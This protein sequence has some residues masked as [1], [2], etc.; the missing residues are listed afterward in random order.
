MIAPADSIGARP[1]R[2]VRGIA[3]FAHLD[4]LRAEAADQIRDG[5]DDV[6]QKRIDSAGIPGCSRSGVS[7]AANGCPSNPLYRLALMFVVARRLGVPKEKLQRGIDWLQSKLDEAYADAEPEPL[8]EVLDRDAEIDAKDDV[9]RL[10]AARGCPESMR[11]LLAVKLTITAQSRITI[12]AL[13]RR[14]A[15]AEGR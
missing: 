12:L 5:F 8:A 15:G 4:R 6:S 14:I 3:L 9:L 2:V 7:R 11:E 10:R 1:A 13:Q